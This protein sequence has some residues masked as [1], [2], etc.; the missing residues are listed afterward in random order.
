ME[1]TEDDAADLLN[2]YMASR[3]QNASA[4]PILDNAVKLVDHPAV[5]PKDMA[6]IEIAQFNESRIAV[7]LGVPPFLVGLPAGGDSMT[8]SNV[9]ALFDFHDRQTLKTLAAHVMGALSYW[10]LPRGQAAELNRDEYSRPA[11]DARAAAWE[12]LIASGVVGADEVRLY[13]RFQGE[14]PRRPPETSETPE[15]DG[16]AM[17]ALTGGEG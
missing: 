5:S 1:L 3:V 14:G 16:T 7:L 13:E 15:Q 10:A 11:F 17:T 6:M 4:P 2:Q 12:K 9:S 8:Y